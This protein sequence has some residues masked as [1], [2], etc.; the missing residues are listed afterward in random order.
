MKCG[1]NN[2]QPVTPMLFLS[3]RSPTG[4]PAF[5]GGNAVL[6]VFGNAGQCLRYFIFVT[7][8]R[9]QLATI[10]TFCGQTAIKIRVYKL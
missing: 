3:E 10:D 6:E 7:S 5:K 2:Q 8:D 1:F 9:T 4:L